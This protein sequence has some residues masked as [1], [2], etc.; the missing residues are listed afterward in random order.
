MK[1]ALFGIFLCCTIYVSGCAM[2]TAWKNIPPPGGCDECHTA[3]ISNDWKVSYQAPILTDERGREAFQTAE[4]NQRRTG[5]PDSS[6]QLR[7][8]EDTKCFDCHKSP[9]SMHK[10]RA[11]RFH[12]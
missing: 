1:T 11:G 7:K 5:K 3:A 8:T 2:F 12:H 10:D 6:L 9:D 4:Y